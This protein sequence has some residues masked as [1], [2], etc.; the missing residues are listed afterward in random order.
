MSYGKLLSESNNQ[1]KGN[2]II[3]KQLKERMT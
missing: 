1:Q 2:E 3:W